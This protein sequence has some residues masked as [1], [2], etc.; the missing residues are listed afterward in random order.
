MER[1][2]LRNFGFSASRQA[3][4]FS[5]TFFSPVNE[6]REIVLPH[7]RDA[8]IIRLALDTSQKRIE[9]FRKELEK[10]R[11]HFLEDSITLVLEREN[12]IR[13]TLSQIRSTDGFDFH[14]EIKIFFVGEE[15][16]DA[17]GVF[18]EWI[19]LVLQQIFTGHICEKKQ[20]L[21]KEKTSDLNLNNKRRSFNLSNREK[22]KFQRRSIA[23]GKNDENRM[24][25]D[26]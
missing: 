22:L 6:S 21:R 1:Y 10:L 11:I 18:K 24:H 8:K 12:V 9:Y 4:F 15:A 3:L 2:N 16:Q 17:G 20:T 25:S 19:F 7:K 14:K 5:K 23:R 13:D 26:I